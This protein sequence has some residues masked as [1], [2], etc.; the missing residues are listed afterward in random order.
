MEPF[1]QYPLIVTVS[2]SSINFLE[3]PPFKLTWN[4][5]AKKHGAWG[6]SEGYHKGDIGNF[7]ARGN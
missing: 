2:L 6:D 5:T 4:P 7:V 3:P 1:L